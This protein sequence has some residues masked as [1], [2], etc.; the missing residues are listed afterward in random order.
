MVKWWN[1]IQF[2]NPELFVLF[3]I[4]PL[5]ILGYLFRLKKQKAKIKLSGFHFLPK[6]SSNI[7]LYLRHLPFAFSLVGF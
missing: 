5:L 3:A 4:I 1:D 7:Q 6:E 2:A